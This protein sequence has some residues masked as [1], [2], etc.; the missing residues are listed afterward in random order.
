MLAVCGSVKGRDAGPERGFRGF[1]AIR[2][3]EVLASENTRRLFAPASVA[4]LVVAAAALHHLGPEFRVI[5]RVRATGRLSGATLD[6][7][8]VIEAAGDP[9]W[10]RRFFDSDPRKPLRD[11]A[12]QLRH[13]G[14][15]RVTGDL[16]VDVHRFPGRA[17][18]LSRPL[19]E[20]AFGFAA[21]TSA[22]AIDENAVTVE[23]APGR[24]VGEPGTASIAGDAGGLRIEGTPH[25][26]SRQRHGKGTVDFRPLWG[27]PVIHVRG[28][29]PISEP[30]YRIEVAV[31]DADR[32]AGQ[33]LAV[34]L[35]R[36]GIELAGEVKVS[37]QPAMSAD[38]SPG[39][40]VAAFQSPQLAEML[41]PILTDSS[42]WI[43]EMLLRVVAAE[44]LGEGRDDEGLELERRFLEEEV[45]LPPEA[46]RLDDASGLSPYNL[47]SPEA[48][49]GLLR[50]VLRQPWRRPFI[51]ALAR[52]GTGTLEVWR[53]LPSSLAA[54]T[55]MIRDTVALAGYLEPADSSGRGEPIVFACFLNHRPGDR[56][57][58]RAE[59][60]RLLRNW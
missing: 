21:P 29:Y 5:T 52:P 37:R 18:A 16:V 47:L 59:I 36:E 24:R 48:V 20:I 41:E 58:L 50:W 14:L 12:R 46:F 34:E 35:R 4:K 57:A 53:G 30:S 15:R 8:L 27:S 11:L 28:E 13:R 40:V 45:G 9:T 32:Y 33:A 44:V 49:V 6:G 38:Q 43:A 10:S 23:I 25:T 51:D 55:G 54:K 2:G 22:L 19:S 17:Y 42:N 56:G 39:P 26:V 3:A 7:D 1:L 60:A 31:P